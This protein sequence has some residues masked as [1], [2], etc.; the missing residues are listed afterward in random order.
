ML[1]KLVI[2]IQNEGA[3]APSLAWVWSREN[4]N[5]SSV[6]VSNRQQLASSYL[7]CFT[8][9]EYP[10]PLSYLQVDWES[11]PKSY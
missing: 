1:I 10:H 5:A 9:R 4:R 11:L 7:K 3:I 6:S 2:G 8:A